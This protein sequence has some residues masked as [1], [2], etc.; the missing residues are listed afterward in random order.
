MVVACGRHTPA[1]S[2]E[3]P[4]PA[5][6]VVLVTIDTLRA[7]RLGCYGNTTVE[8]PNIDRLAREGVVMTNVS[9]HVPLT[10]PSH[11]TILTGLYPA[12]HGIRDNV[13]PSL[14]DG[15]PT[16]AEQF[17]AAGFDT[18][19]FV[20]SVVLS[21]QSGLARGF[22]TYSQKFAD[23]E[24]ND[25][26]FLNTIQRRGDIAT[27][28][29]VDW[30]PSH[31]GNR[32]FLWL[33]LYD[34]HDPYEPPEP[35]ASRYADRPYDG[36][37]AWSDELVGRLE[38][39]LADNGL[40]DD[41]LVVVTSD[42]GEG[43]GEHQENVHGYF[44]YETT[45]HVPLVARGPGVKAGARID[46][47]TRL[48]DLYPTLVASAGLTPSAESN[49]QG[50]SLLGAWRGEQSIGDEPAF[51]ESLTPLIHYGWSDLRSVRDGR[52]KYILAPHPEL[53]DLSRDPQEQNNLEPAEGA[54]ARAMRAG[55]EAQLRAEAT[56][57][58]SGPQQ[59]ASV[60]ADL[61]EKLGALGYVSAGGP[62]SGK[63]AGADPKDKIDEYKTLNRLMREGMVRLREKDYA[64]SAERFR[65]LTKIGVDSFEVHYYFARALAGRGACAEA[66]PHYA[67]AI[68]RLPAFGQAYMGLADCQMAA[69]NPTAAVA[70]LERGVAANPRD[71]QLIERTA[72]TWRRLE[73]PEKAIA[74]YESE[75]PLAPADAL[76]RVRLGELY[77][78]A[79]DT[80]RSLA[81]LREAVALDSKEASYWNSLGMVLGGAGD[82]AGAEQ[83]F[84]EAVQRDE[85]DAQYA[86]N[87][88]LAL[89]RQGRPTEAATWYAK[90][91]DRNPKFAAARQHL[92]SSRRER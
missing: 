20:S 28:E 44:V 14:K 24:E 78:D 80:K 52:W 9:S 58:K 72:E 81:V 88:G 86:Y 34:P 23:E 36:E 48:I 63:S 64:G 43:L 90:A 7:D 6:H 45:L 74:L 59:T 2:P 53:Y 70:T 3:A 66:S 62:T 57:V 5:R 15:I 30:I 41:T 37:V 16:L 13:A 82:L 4:A 71:V 92:D 73:H 39:A 85:Q 40:R 12:Q 54:R 50:R 75:L 32:F 31:R 55:L 68:E 51:A 18:A 76:I 60:P 29:A 56:E 38:R 61:L 33:H 47:T 35:Y 1:R 67:R 77:R 79:G 87:L 49:R 19:G 26:R 11:V 65:Q 89:E 46:G 8:T 21:S 17:K 91:L 83:A 42:H 69:R 22:Q 27:G 84:R 25:A 10:R